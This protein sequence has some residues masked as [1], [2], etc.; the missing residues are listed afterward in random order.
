M[1][2]R[3]KIIQEL[4]KNPNGFTISELSKKL[5]LS[6]Q[7]ISNCFAFLEG[8]Q[9]VEIRKAGMAKIYYWGKSE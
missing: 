2:N 8:A 6:R 5:K 1:K 3:E 9:K 4:R 7:T